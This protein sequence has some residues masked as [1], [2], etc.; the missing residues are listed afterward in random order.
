MFEKRPYFVIGDLAVERGRR[1]GR[2]RGGT[3]LLVGDGWP[4]LMQAWLAGMVLG[5]LVA[6]I[7]SAAASLL[8]GAL[9]IML[10][11]MTTGMAAGMLVGMRAA[12]GSAAGAR[13]DR[14]DDRCGRAGGH[15]H[16]ERAPAGQGG[17][18]GRPDPAEVGSR[19]PR[20]RSGERVRAGA[21]LGAVQAASV[22]ADAGQR[23]LRGHRDRPGHPVL[24][25]RAA[26]NGD[27]HQ[28]PHAGG[29]SSARGG[30][31]GRP[32]AAA[33]RRA[34]PR[35]SRRHLRPGLHLVHFLL[36]AAASRRAPRAQA[37]AEAGRP[38]AHV[39]AHG[40]PLPS[41]SASC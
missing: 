36:G 38:T 13:G 24:P 30:I 10:P 37:G 5:G 35:L 29:R 4:V 39:R 18:G 40:Q 7:L 2:R 28:R 41:R 16:P 1:R 27:R 19:R 17:P 8:F 3:A 33:D 25:A 14:R 9:E 15:L 21:P 34:L 23:G 22:R 6:T 32:R 26:D 11:V 12:A 31:P 20:L